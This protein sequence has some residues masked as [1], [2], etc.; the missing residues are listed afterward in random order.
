[1]KAR[2]LESGIMYLKTSWN[3]RNSCEAENKWA[4]IRARQFK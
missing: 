1:L 2:T 4:K 3:P